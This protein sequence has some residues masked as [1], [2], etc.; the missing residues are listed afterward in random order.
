MNPASTFRLTFFLTTVVHAVLVGGML[1]TSRRGSARGVATTAPLMLEWA[2]PAIAPALPEPKFPPATVLTSAVS[3][4]QRAEALAE[5][6][7]PAHRSPSLAVPRAKSDVPTPRKSL[8]SAAAKPAARRSPA[9]NSAEPPPA[10][11]MRAPAS[12]APV[13]ASLSAAA[14]VPAAAQGHSPSPILHDDGTGGGSAA[15]ADAIAAYHEKLQRLFEGR[16]RQPQGISGLTDAP[17][18]RIALTILADGAIAARKLVHP[19]GNAAVDASAL[20]AAESVTRTD[21]LP[22]ELGVASYRVLIKFVLH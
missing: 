10:R 21:P 8:W 18:A 11:P 6:A 13:P 7:S 14:R 16:W 17:T 9:R 19:S 22:R 1:L 2:S 20:A 12:T 3:V 4:P 15:D 5:A